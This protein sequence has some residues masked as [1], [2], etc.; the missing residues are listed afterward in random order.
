M[1]PSNCWLTP[2]PL[3][4][5][6]RGIDQAVTAGDWLRDNVMTLGPVGESKVVGGAESDQ[7]FVRY[8]SSEYLRAMETA[9]LLNIEDSKWFAEMFLRERDWGL[10]DLLSQEERK[11]RFKEELESRERD[12][13]FWS[14]PGGESLADVC[15]WV[16]LEQAE[17]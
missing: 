14:P 17:S 10:M 9:A 4:H 5:L 6:P 11:A 12:R 8:Y 3:L 1:K 15:M 16:S 2:P 7:A 13:F